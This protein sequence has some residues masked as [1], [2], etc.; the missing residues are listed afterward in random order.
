[1]DDPRLDLARLLVATSLADNSRRTGSLHDSVSAPNFIH[2]SLL[3]RGFMVDL[4][5]GSI[6]HLKS[7]SPDLKVV[8]IAEEVTV[9]WHDDENILQQWTLPAGCFVLA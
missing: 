1:L 3:K 5:I 7:G 2:S 8:K 9:E 4:E 6:V